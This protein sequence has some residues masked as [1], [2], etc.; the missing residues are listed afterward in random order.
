[1]DALQDFSQLLSHDFAQYP[2]LQ[3]TLL[4]ALLIGFSCSL[5]SVFVNAKRMA[6]L[7]QG[8]SFAALPG[9]ALG[10][11]LYPALSAP[12]TKVYA[13]ALGFCFAAAWLMAWTSRKET[14]S[15]DAA[16]GVYFC[17]SMVLGQIFLAQRNGGEQ[18]VDIAPYLFGSLA[19]VSAQELY[20]LAGIAAAVLLAILFLY[21]EFFA[22]CF[23]PQ[24]A[25]LTGVPIRFLHYLLFFLLTAAAVFSVKA[26]G[27]VLVTS[28]LILPGA[29]AALTARRFANLFPIALVIGLVSSAAGV[30]AADRIALK[31]PPSLFVISILFGVF[32][33]L[34]LLNRRK[35]A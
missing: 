13:I 18:I 33:L 30:I 20:W 16:I 35:T 29:C 27:M 2:F 31:L 3:R 12:D 7:G 10:L 24:Y 9:L 23:D 1:M 14:I 15:E 21:K 26:A 19:S 5:L 28:L 4:A 32:F 8:I 34:S 11:W 17:V 22:F 25:A 6:F